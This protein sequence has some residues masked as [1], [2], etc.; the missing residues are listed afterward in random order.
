M[1]SYA[2]L[3]ASPMHYMRGK[4]FIPYERY[5]SLD[6]I[7]QY[8]LKDKTPNDTVKEII[9]NTPKGK[10]FDTSELEMFLVMYMPEEM[11]KK[12]E[13]ELKKHPIF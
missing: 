7:E 12:L 4:R 5:C 11:I 2:A 6:E 13:E 10:K 9:K 1:I 3:D 8:D